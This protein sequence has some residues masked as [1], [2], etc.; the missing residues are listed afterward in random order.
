M[1]FK[2]AGCTNLY[3][4]FYT[5][6]S[7]RKVGVGIRKYPIGIAKRCRFTRYGSQADC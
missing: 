3:P 1:D 6:K 7:P 2:P 4:Y 5:G